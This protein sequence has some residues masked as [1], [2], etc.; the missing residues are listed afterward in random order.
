MKKTTS[1]LSKVLWAKVLQW[2]KLKYAVISVILHLAIFVEHELVSERETDRQTHGRSASTASHGKNWSEFI[3]LAPFQFHS[4][5]RSTCWNISR[6]ES[7]DG[8]MPI[9]NKTCVTSSSVTNPSPS[10][11]KSANTAFNS[12]KN[13]ENITC[14]VFGELCRWNSTTK[15]S[16]LNQTSS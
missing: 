2:Q 3:S 9:D 12:A 13:N 1:S 10:L 11:S 4:P 16:K 14:K 7:R 6:I 15:Q 5:S 8:L